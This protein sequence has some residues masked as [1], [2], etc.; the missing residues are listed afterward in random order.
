MCR[1]LKF[2]WPCTVALG[3]AALLMGGGIVRAQAQAQDDPT[4]DE[5]TVTGQAVP[6]AVLGDI[7]PEN[8][9]TPRDI[10]MYGVGTVSE[11][12]DE[13][14]LQTTSGQSR[15][16]AGPIVLV[17]G[18]RISGVNE[19]SDL[20][21]EAILRLDILPEEVALKYGYSS[22]QKVVNIILRRRFAAVTSEGS[23]GASTEGGDE[24]AR[25]NGTLTRIRDNR[26]LNAALSAQTQSSITEAQR[27]ITPA[28]SGPA[29]D[30]VYRT[31]QPNR[32]NYSANAVYA[33]PLSNTVSA[34]TNL[35]ASH[36]T[37][38]SLNG[39][40]LSSLEPLERLA[41][42]TSLHLG[43]TLNADL[44]GS[45]RVSLVG[46]LDHSD[47]DT[48]TDRLINPAAGTFGVDKARA[49]NDSADGSVLATRRLL[50]LPAGDTLI[51][52][53]GG[54][55]ASRTR[56]TTTGLRSQPTQ[57]LSRSSSN[58]RM[59]LDLPVTKR[60]G[61]GG[62]IGSLTANLNAAATRTSQFHTLT[63]YGYGLNW[64]P[65]SSLS[66]IAAISEDRRA[67]SAQQLVSPTLTVVGTS[68]YDYLT[69]QSVLVS[70]TTGGNPLLKADDRRTFKLGATLKPFV[71]HDFTLTANYSE[72][73]TKNAILGL[74]GI[75]ESLE[76]AFPD[77]FERDAED[78]LVSIDTRPVNVAAQK[79][80]NLRWGFNLTQVLRQPQR[81]LFGNRPQ[82]ANRPPFAN[83]A[84]P[85][86]RPQA[87][88]APDTAPAGAAAPPD[89]ANTP[90]GGGDADPSTDEV[91]VSGRRVQN[92][93]GPGSG[94]RGF[95]PRP[96]G[97]G[98]GLGGRRGG[99]G[100]GGPG[101]GG[102]GRGAGRGGF[103]GDDGARLQLSVYHTWLLHNDIILRDGRASIDLL[104]GGTIGGSPP[105]RH[106][107]Q[108]N[109]GVTDNG[110]G[111][112]LT[113][114]WRSAGRAD[115]AGSVGEL[116][117]GSLGTLDLRAFTDL[118][119]RLPMKTWA[120][121]LRAT[122]TVQNLLNERQKVTNEAGVVPQAYQPGYLNPTGRAV[123]LA[124][125][126]I[127]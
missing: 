93:D 124:V 9:L 109:G 123:L 37:A 88:N 111:L 125:R 104:N 19:V 33:T 76:A 116:H 64:S 65:A 17:N 96:G 77:R 86:I 106:L 51:S 42:S 25:G 53:Q 61:W 87:A 90:P 4:F 79:R 59:S 92:D 31:L 2:L 28:T 66:V 15:D 3:L 23:V 103:G 80:S 71:N 41:T 11:L 101:G 67:P 108:V 52:L 6:G 47:S 18:R 34:S 75:S 39:L 60:G 69:G 68:V 121:G 126:K 40:A 22:D 91:I 113:G 82:F 24:R 110:I 1:M 30:P 56:S 10:R 85:S 38:R 50:R 83:R 117:F 7:P 36:G 14:A 73:R 95:R 99:P 100:G 105:S 20:P 63:T 89:V 74:S 94:N 84:Q 43:T 21:T 45:W 29:S 72:S 27:G 102:F 35:T 58:A 26:R 55:Q 70:S 97:F 32:D 44:P 13:I 78:Q 120:R 12:L 114:E 54:L 115:L 16:G 118:G 48:D 8:S 122:L 112:R 98:G 62:A 81:P 5:V 107:V 119:Q 127:F 57:S 46:A 49:R